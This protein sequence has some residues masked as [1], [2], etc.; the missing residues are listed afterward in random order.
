MAQ[1]PYPFPHYK[2]AGTSSARMTQEPA[3]RALLKGIVDVCMPLKLDWFFDLFRPTATHPDLVLVWGRKERSLKAIAMAEKLKLPVITLEDGFL[4]S[5]DL[6]GSDRNPLLSIIIDPIGTY[7][8]STQP[9]YLE[10]LLNN[11]SLYTPELMSR[12]QFALDLFL[13][14]RLSKYNSAPDTLPDWLRNETRDIVLV[15]DQTKGDASIVGAQANGRS[16]LTM[17]A[18]AL[19]MHP[20]ALIVVKTH[21][22]VIAGKKEGYLTS[23]RGHQRLR[24]LSDDIHPPALLDRVKEVFTVSSQLGFEAL[25]R[26]IPVNCYGLPFYAGWGLTRDAQTCERR[27][28]RRNVQE[29]F[30]AAMLLYPRYYS[31]FTCKPCDLEDVI[32]LLQEQRRQHQRLGQ[33]IHAIGMSR[34]KQEVVRDFLETPRNQVTFHTDPRDAVQAMRKDHGQLIGWASK[35]SSKIQEQLEEAGIPMLQMEDG[36]I[37]SIGLGA[38]LTRAASLVLDGRGMYYDPRTPSD[39]EH[40]LEYGTIPMELVHRAADIRHMILH[41]QLSKYNLSSDLPLPD[42]PTDKRILLVPG[43]VE[44]DASVRCGSPEITNNRDLL[45]AVRLKNPDAFILY[46]PHPDV[47]AGYRNGHVPDAENCADVVLGSI[48]ITQLYPLVDEVHTMTSLTGFEALLRDK[49]VVCYGLPFY[50][51]WGLTR[52]EMHCPRRTRRRTLNELIAATLI[53]YPTYVDPVTRLVCPVEIIIDRLSGKLP[54][55]TGAHEGIAPIFRWL[56][57]FLVL[58][59]R[60]MQAPP[61]SSTKKNK[62]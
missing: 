46:K 50:A 10:D 62:S 44:D 37:R 41:R 42:L 28:A 14:A 17:L 1:Y 22:D 38:S 40:L 26:G 16:F 30:A 6:A 32:H 59:R 43:Q 51:G 8:D 57:A 49:T 31:P 19:T 29:L 52:D 34:W 12:A 55:T 20:N 48:G 24:L 11:D 53:L 60:S 33:S 23:Q 58:S 3:V 27:T 7:T 18:D 21:P 35:L 5:L 47:V 25:L 4:R 9:S 39:L 45:Q 54:A 56:Q 36:F 2:L 13:Q 61:P 15:V